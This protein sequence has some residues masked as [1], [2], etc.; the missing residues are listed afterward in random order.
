MN[1]DDVFAKRPA[2]SNTYE[3][4]GVRGAQVDNTGG[5][6]AAFRLQFKCGADPQKKPA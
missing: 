2:A 3:A 4:S 5:M 1:E 6:G